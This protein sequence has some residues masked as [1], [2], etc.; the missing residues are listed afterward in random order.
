MGVEKFKPS[1]IDKWYQDRLKWK[2]LYEAELKKLREE[3]KVKENKDK[4]LDNQLSQLEHRVSNIDLM[5]KETFDNEVKKLEEELDALKE[6]WKASQNLQAIVLK[7]KKSNNIDIAQVNEAF[8]DHS[9]R[10]NEW[11]WE[12][13][14]N[15]DDLVNEGNS[16]YDKLIRKL[17]W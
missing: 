7:S 16:W 10:S 12:S 11:R 2:K 5:N 1:S 8:P 17:V 4:T 14:K 3:L 9:K 6:S 15:V 13:V